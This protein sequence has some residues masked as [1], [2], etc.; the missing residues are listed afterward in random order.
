MITIQN[1]LRNIAPMSASSVKS[2]NALVEEVDIDK[3]EVFVKKGQ[4]NHQEY[5]V[6]EGICR[7]FVV[8]HEAEEITISFF[9]EGSIISPYVSRTTN[10]KS[11]L[12]FQALTD[13]KLGMMDAAS[14]EN[15]MV[16]NLEI[17]HFGNTVL[18]NEL[19]QKV[20]KEID[21]ASAPAKERLLK[22][23]GVYPQ[24]ENLVP[25][26]TIASYLGITNISLSRL[27]R[28]LMK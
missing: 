15:L 7:S 25:H 18:R 9:A 22:F 21:L 5:F 23:R 10:G 20:S 19:I 16:E 3:S 11:D 13:L 27:R 26:Q 28:D 1:I 4:F 8:N 2:I 14:F 12:N 17:R 6:L 24:M